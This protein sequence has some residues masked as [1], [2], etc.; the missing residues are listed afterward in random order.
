[1]GKLILITNNELYKG[2]YEKVFDMSGLPNG[3]YLVSIIAGE[4]RIMRKVIKQ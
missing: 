3:I 2:S 1:L 4:K